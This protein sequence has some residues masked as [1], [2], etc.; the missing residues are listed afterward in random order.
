MSPAVVRDCSV[1]NR[2]SVPSRESHSCISINATLCDTG[3]WLTSS[4]PT[5][6]PTSKNLRRKRW[7]AP[8]TKRT[9]PLQALLMGPPPMGPL[10]M[11]IDVFAADEQDR[12]TMDLGRFGG[13]A[14]RVL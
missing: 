4:P 11:G 12:Q 10:P 3:S 14:K 6:A 8:R 9:W 2:S 1:L 5:S 13:L 7:I